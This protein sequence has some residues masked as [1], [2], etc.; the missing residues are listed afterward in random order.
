VKTVCFNLATFEL[1]VDLKGEREQG[2]PI[3]W[4]PW[5]LSMQEAAERLQSLQLS[6]LAKQFG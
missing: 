6:L 2:R 4:M 3:R 1:I 5:Q